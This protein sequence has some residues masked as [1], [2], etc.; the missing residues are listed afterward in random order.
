MTA[1]DC[2]SEPTKWTGSQGNWYVNESM[3][4]LM[5]YKIFIAVYAQKMV[6][7]ME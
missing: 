6:T 7:S 3:Q 4:A 5:K 2:W 1:L